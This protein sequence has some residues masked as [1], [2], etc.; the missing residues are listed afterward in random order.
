MWCVNMN[1]NH[2]PQDRDHGGF[3]EYSTE[4]SSK[5]MAVKLLIS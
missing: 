5:K 1:W 4:T 3:C 2:L